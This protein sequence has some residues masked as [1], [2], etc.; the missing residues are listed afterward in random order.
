M[1]YLKYNGY[2]GTI[3]PDLENNILYG[4]LAFIRDLVTYEANTIAEL[5]KEFKVSVDLY[6]QACKED[7]KEPDIPFK[8][9][10]N[11]RVNPE[12][13]RKIAEISLEKDITI[14]AFI[15]KTLEKEINNYHPRT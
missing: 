14:N 3:E 10:F 11:I 7:G 13:H 6:L 15:N 8:G 4:K 2:I 12:L 1:K 5:A 9:V